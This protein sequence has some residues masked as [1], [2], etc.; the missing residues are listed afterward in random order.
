MAYL[1]ILAHELV[2]HG[3]N[4]WDEYNDP[5]GI[6][7][8]DK[9]KAATGRWPE[10]D[11]IMAGDSVFYDRHWAAGIDDK[12]NI[13][14]LPIG[15]DNTSELDANGSWFGGIWGE[16]RLKIVSPLI[17]EAEKQPRDK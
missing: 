14:D 12:S 7:W 2:G 3:M 17:T 6:R 1:A 13:P 9:F 8:A 16:E 15:I 11:S 5:K 4:N 10:N